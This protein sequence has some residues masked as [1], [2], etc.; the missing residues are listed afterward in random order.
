MA[1]FKVGDRVRLVRDNGGSHYGYKVGMEGTV[2]VGYGLILCLGGPK[3]GY[4]VTFDNH[5][6]HAGCDPDE[7]A[8]LVNPDELAWQTCRTL[9]LTPP[10]V[11]ETANA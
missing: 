9:M 10:K 2:D 7:I 5:P 3:F 1:K 6:L 4:G 8:P 11:E